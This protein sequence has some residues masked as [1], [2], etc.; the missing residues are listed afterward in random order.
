MYAKL[1]ERGWRVHSGT[2]AESSSQALL[3]LYLQASRRAGA[4]APC[5]YLRQANRRIRKYAH[6]HLLCPPWTTTT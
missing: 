3:Q 6:E 1:F 2:K 4:R 5:Y